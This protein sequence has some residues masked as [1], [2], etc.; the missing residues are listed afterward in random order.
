MD[1]NNKIIYDWLTFS[2]RIHSVPDVITMLGLEGVQFI[3]LDRG[4]NG[5]P[6]CL[7]FGGISICYGGREDM[8]VC[9]CM[10]GQGCRTFE[11]HGNGNYKAIFDEVNFNITEMNISRLDVAYDDFDNVLDIDVIVNYVSQQWYTARFN[12]WS[13][14]YGSDG[15]CVGLGSPR[16]DTYIRIYD[17]KA[18]QGRDDIDHWVRFEVQLRNNCAVGFSALDGSIGNNFF[19]VVNN[20]L[21]FVEPSESDTNKRRWNTADWWTEFLQSLDVISIAARPGTEYN[22]GKL[23]GY[24]YGQCCGAVSTLIDIVGLQEFLTDLRYNLSSHKL[25]P[26]YKDLKNQ[27]GTS[28]DGVLDFLRSRGVV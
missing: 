23:G 8:G 3:S 22:L 7:H 5:Y 15:I 17:K 21:R 14:T 2:T 13:V 24:V 6:C 16:S 20:Y 11:T 19:G 9:C 28:S 18:E 26:K 4:M 27:H 10:S 12:K 25:N 1:T